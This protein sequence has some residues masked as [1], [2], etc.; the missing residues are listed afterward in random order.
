M[1]EI[2]SHDLG[3]LRTESKFEWVCPV[4]GHYINFGH[5]NYDVPVCQRC[6]HAMERKRYYKEMGWRQG[7]FM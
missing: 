5:E 1:M 7:C 6:G 2:N 4:C 3:Y